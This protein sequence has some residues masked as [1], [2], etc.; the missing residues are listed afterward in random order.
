MMKMN[1]KLKEGIKKKIALISLVALVLN[2]MMAGTLVAPV[3]NV[4]LA[5]TPPLPNW[6]S[7]VWST[8]GNCMS[9]PANEENPDFELELT[10]LS[11]FIVK[12]EELEE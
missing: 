4:A 8:P 5:V 12:I 1:K 7:V 3:N 6:E 2:L 11:E 9:D 10:T